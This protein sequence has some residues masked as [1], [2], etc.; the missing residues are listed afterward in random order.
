[1]ARI[2]TRLPSLPRSSRW[3]LAGWVMLAGSLVSALGL[4]A[5]DLT[6]PKARD[7]LVARN[8][9]QLMQRDHLSKHP[10]D[11]EIALRGLKQF[12]KLLDPAKLYFLQSDV[13]EFQQKAR[14]LDEALRDGDIS[15]GY[16][17][18]KRYLQRVDERL[19]SIEKLIQAEHDF[20]AK[21]DVIVNAD[22]AKY[23][24]SI[25]ESDDRWRRRIKYDLL[26]LKSDKKEGK[27]ARE[28]LLRR[29]QSF[30]KRMKQTDSDELLEMYLTAF[31][32][33]FDPHTTYMSP[34]SLDNFMISMSLQLEGIGAALQMQDGYTVV[35]KVIPGGAADKDGRLKPE[36]RIVSVGQGEDGEMVEVLDMKLNDVVDK[37][38]GKANTIVRLGVIPSGTTET[39]IFNITRA[40]IELSDSEARGVVF[41]EGKKDDGSAVKIGVIDLPSFYMDMDGAKKGIEDFKSTTRDVRRLLDDFKS[42]QVDVVVLD[43]RHNGG[44]SLTEAINLTGLFIDQGPVVQVKDPDGKVQHYDDLERGMAWDGPLVVVTSKFSA[45]ASEIL[46]GAIQDYG[47][48][49]IVGDDAT[50][51]KGTVQSMLNLGDQLFRNPAQPRNLGALKIT[52][53]QF[54]RPNGDSTQRRGVLA[55]I[56]MP[57]ITNHMDVG[58][59]D[60]DYALAF[61]KVAPARYARVEMVNGDLIGRLRTASQQRIEKSDDFAKLSKRIDRYR[62]FKS[63]KS[64]SVNEDEFFADRRDLNAEKE[65]EKQFEQQANGKGKDEVVK[66]DF[67]FNEVLAIAQDYLKELKAQKVAKAN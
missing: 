10:L 3:V 8:I 58:E 34:N 23:A 41:E 65:E 1:M 47:R 44:G 9:M 40:K 38:R 56:A 15:F 29:Y 27:E 33:S 5:A 45:S 21:E 12:L 14:E 53:Q 43:L 51:G 61:D 19:A 48:G 32:T 13:E 7:R 57:S 16:T 22:A 4:L 11:D 39:K 20:T 64:Q 24:T 18:F 2:N 60:L 26:I 6:Q 30:A 66:R 54:Y 63:R 36:D 35:S 31:T 42:K 52:M 62:D 55:D 46:A 28:R 17:I 49:I 67:Y 50:H 59:S 37:V 25:E